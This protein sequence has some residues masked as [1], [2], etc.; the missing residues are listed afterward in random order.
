MS[1]EIEYYRYEDPASVDALEFIESVTKGIMLEDAK[2]E[3]ISPRTFRL[4]YGDSE[5]GGFCH[6]DISLRAANSKRKS[7]RGHFTVKMNLT[8]ADGTVAGSKRFKDITAESLAVSIQNI[9]REVKKSR[10]S[11]M[12]E[13]DEFHKVVTDGLTALGYAVIGGS[14]FSMV[15]RGNNKNVTVTISELGIFRAVVR[16]TRKVGGVHKAVETGAPVSADNGR[17]LVDFVQSL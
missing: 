10:S 5:L 4:S 6:Y 12:G 7:T 17:L 2:I 16:L 14:K 3:R 11:A 13:L 1:N 9:Y 8:M 15:F